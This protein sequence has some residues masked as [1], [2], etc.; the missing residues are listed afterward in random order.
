MLQQLRQTI[1]QAAPGATETISYNIPT[2]KKIA[3]YAA[4][5]E[6]IGFYPG[7][8]A[9]TAFKDK[10]TRYKTSKGTIQFPIDKSLPTGLIKEIV[11]FRVKVTNKNDQ[12]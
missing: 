6:H 3:S 1:K 5:K 8:A 12:L 4:Y 7:A 11:K 10:L 2:F 9:L